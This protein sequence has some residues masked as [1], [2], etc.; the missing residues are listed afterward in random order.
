[1]SAEELVRI[2]IPTYNRTATVAAPSFSGGP[3]S[4]S[5]AARNLVRTAKRVLRR[6]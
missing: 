4:S 2:L 6:R 3:E 1:M 5:P